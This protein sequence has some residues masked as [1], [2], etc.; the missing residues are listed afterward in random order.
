MSLFRYPR[1][2]LAPVLFTALLSTFLRGGYVL[3]SLKIVARVVDTMFDLELADRQWI[4][5]VPSLRAARSVAPKP[6]IVTGRIPAEIIVRCPVPM[7]VWG[8]LRPIHTLISAPGASLTPTIT[9]P[10][11]GIDQIL[12]AFFHSD[13]AFRA[14]MTGPRLGLRRRDT[15][16]DELAVGSPMHVTR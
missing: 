1:E 8:L 11:R 3:K 9:C 7:I 2:T 10:F 14:V 4:A 13:I 12:V 16:Q 15:G 6:P 5:M